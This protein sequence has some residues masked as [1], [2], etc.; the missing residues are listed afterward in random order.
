MSDSAFFGHVPP[1]LTSLAREIHEERQRNLPPDARNDDPSSI[2]ARTQRD[3]A[4]DDVTRARH[5]HRI[6]AGDA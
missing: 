6:E 3:R 5:H 1:R 4:R 2:A